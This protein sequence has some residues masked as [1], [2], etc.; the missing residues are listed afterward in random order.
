[1]NRGHSGEKIYTCK[2]D[3][4]KSLQYVEKTVERFSLV[5]Y[6]YCL[7]DD[8]YHL[9]IETPEPNLSSAV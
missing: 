1:M 3:R 2:R 6:S 7:M 8:H 9:L 5:V 4:E